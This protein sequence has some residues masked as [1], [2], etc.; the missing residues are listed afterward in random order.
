FLQDL[1]PG[2]RCDLCSWDWKSKAKVL[3]GQTTA[4]SK[5]RADQGWQ[6]TRTQVFAGDTYSLKSE[7]EWSLSK[8]GASVTAAGNESGAGQLL[9]II[10]DDYELS[11]PFVLGAA[12][13][14]TVPRN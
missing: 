1:E 4:F 5:I 10:F 8:A 3:T 14:F 13:S 11:E 7:G 6:A 2:Y 12:E 9:G